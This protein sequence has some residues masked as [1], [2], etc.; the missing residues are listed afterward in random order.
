MK[1]LFPSRLRQALATVATIQP[2]FEA[3]DQRLDNLG[4]NQGIMLSSLNASK[5]STDLRDYEFKVFSQWGADGIIQHLIRCVEIR[6]K[7]FVEFGVEDFFES[8]CRFLLMKDNWQGFVIDGSM[9]HVKRIRQSYFYWKHHLGS[10]CAFITRENINELLKK[11]GFDEDLGILSVDIDG[12]DY[13]VLQS[14]TAFKPRILIC[15]YNGVFGRDRKISIPYEP[16]FYRTGKHYSNLY[17]G[18][19]LGAMTHLAEK[20]GYVLVGTNSI[21][22]NAFYVRRDLMNDR[23]RAMTAAQAW[24]PSHVRESRNEKG[25][26]NYLTGDARLALMRGMPVLNVESGALETL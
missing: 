1:K 22:S 14:I 7:T 19:S 12:N 24:F 18:A 13:H 23:L 2:R 15:E 25:E 5:T 21:G 16:D 26:L 6:H 11:S 17:F 4:I 10:E 8:N 20:K 3:L 9:E